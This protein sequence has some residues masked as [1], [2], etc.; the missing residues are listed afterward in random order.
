MTFERSPLTPLLVTGRLHAVV[1]HNS[2]VEKAWFDEKLEVD[3]RYFDANNISV[4]FDFGDGLSYTTFALS[5]LLASNHCDAGGRGNSTRRQP[6]S[7]GY[8]VQRHLLDHQYGLSHRRA[9]SAAPHQVSQQNAGRYTTA[10]ASR[11][12]EDGPRV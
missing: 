5:K 6:G 3:Y 12:R 11:V 2:F 10:A 9:S 4:Q 8:T 7:V 1:A